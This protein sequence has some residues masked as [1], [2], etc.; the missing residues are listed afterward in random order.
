[1]DPER[2]KNIESKNK[3]RL[4]R[5]IEIAKALGKVPEITRETP[6]YKFI[7]IGLYLSPN[8]LKRKISIRLFARIREGMIQEAKKLHAY[9]LSWK[10]M[11]E[12]G[13]EYRFMALYLQNKIS[14]KE[15][16][17]KLNIEIYK[18]AKRQMTWFKR[19]KE[20]VWFNP[21]ES[22]KIEGYIQNQL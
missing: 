4:I 17:E 22:K 12:L 9:G 13:L 1:M 14:K 15:M 11:E 21:K 10:R 16:L 3:V 7:K 19:D 8:K 2:A 18:Y 20:I 5:A 6:Q